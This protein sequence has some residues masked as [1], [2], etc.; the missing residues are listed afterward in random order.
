[1]LEAV[2]RASGTPTR[3]RGLLVDG[4]F[5]YPRFPRL[6]HLVPTRVV[7]AWP[8]FALDSCWVP[9]SELF[10]SLADLSDRHQE[11]FTNSDGETLFDA[12]TRTAIDWHGATSAPGSCSACDLSAQVVADLGRF[13]DRDALFHQHGQ[14]LCRPARWL[15]DPVLGQRR[16]G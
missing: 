16:A 4:R 9:A 11:G 10:G 6:R 8:E 14:T 13:D 2:A 7:L 1:M 15:A 3:V 5:W 12:L